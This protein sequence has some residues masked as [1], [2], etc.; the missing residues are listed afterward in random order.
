MSYS[1]NNNTFTYFFISQ[2]LITVAKFTDR[3]VTSYL[4]ADKI[5]KKAELI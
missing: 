5:L 2:H 1:Q 4:D 3:Y